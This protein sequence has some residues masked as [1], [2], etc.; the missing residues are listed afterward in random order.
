MTAHPPTDWSAYA[1]C[2]TCDAA[3]GEPCTT[4]RFPMTAPHRTRDTTAQPS[5]FAPLEPK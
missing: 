5:L 3:V 4:G 2:P 1:T